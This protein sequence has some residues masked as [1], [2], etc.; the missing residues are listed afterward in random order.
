MW[1]TNKTKEL[2]F[3]ALDNAT[4]FIVFDTETTG[5]SA[6]KNHIIQISAIKFSISSNLEIQEIERLDC[7]IN[8]SYSLP[9]KIIEITGIT[10]EFLMDKPYEEEVFYDYIYPFFGENPECVIAYNTPFDMRF[11][12]ALYARYGK[13]FKPMYQLDVLEMARDLVEKTDSKKHNLASIAALY[14]VDDGITF[15]CSM[16]DVIAT[17]RLFKVFIKEYE[18][19]NEEKN[20]SHHKKTPIISSMHYWQGYRGCS[21]IYIH[22][23]L[24]AF[25][26]D[27]MKKQWDKKKDNLHNIEEVDMEHLRN[28]AFKLAN[29]TNELEFGRYRG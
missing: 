8:P 20:L 14:G 7:Y 3:E 28:E 25:Y 13:Q 5:F 16:D 19:Q 17:L 24:G 26:Y 12:E 23:N 21:R 9:P 4:E 11:L 27:I 2:L 6:E 22:T 18:K 29:A 10:D 1:R 15:H